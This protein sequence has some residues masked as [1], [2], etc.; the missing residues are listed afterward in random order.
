MLASYG[1]IG[2]FLI[3]AILFSLVMIVLPII[4]KYL[5][6]IPSNPNSIK[7]SIFECGME[8]IGKTWV[9]FNFRYYFYALVFLALDVLVVFLYPWAVQL[10]QLGTF[11][12]YVVLIMVGILLVGYVYA[13]KKKAL[14]WK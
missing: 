11:S 10:K 3:V 8:T 13:W 6:V 5:K 2:L 7:N 4:L 14:E 9:Q 1:L 12:L